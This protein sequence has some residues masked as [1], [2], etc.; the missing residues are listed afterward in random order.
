MRS[1]FTLI[2]GMILGTLSFAQPANDDCN[3]P[4][5]LGNLPACD[6]TIYSNV[7]ATAS[8]IGTR[9][10]P[11]CFNGGTTQ[12][13]VWFTFT[14]PSEIPDVT[15]FLQGTASGPNTKSISN[16]QIA[17]YR[18]D[19]TTNG[20][21]EIGCVSAPT[22]SNQVKL[23]VE[24][25]SGGVTYFVRINDYSATAASNAGDFSLCIDVLQ[26]AI[27]MGDATGSTACFGT[28]YDSGGPDGNYRNFEDL[29][30]T[31]CPSQP[32]SCIEIDLVDYGIEEPLLDIFGD[33]LSF[34]AGSNTSAPLI[35]RVYGQSPGTSFKIQARSECITIRFESD[36]LITDTGFELT[37]RC[38]PDACENR[39]FDNPTEI[40]NL[41]FIQSGFSTCLSAS[42]LSDTPCFNEEF[43]NGPEYVF[44]YNAPGGTCIS[45]EVLGANAGTGVLILDGPPSDPGTTC[46]ARAPGGIINSAN[47]QEAGTYY[48][49]V[50]NGS[51]CTPFDLRIEETT[52]SISPALVDALCNPLNGCAREDGLPT[53]F[54]F[55]PGFQDMELERDVNNGCWLGFGLEPN[56]YWFT[57]QANADGP[58]GFILDSADPSIQSDLDFNVWG[59]FTQEEVCDNKDEVI[60]FIR[61]NQPIRSS[62]SPTPGATGLANRHPVFNTPVTDEYDCDDTPGPDGDDFVRTIPA[63][64]GEV[65]V[66]LINDWSGFIEEDG[67]IVD[68]SPSSPPVISRLTTT[69]EV[70]DTAICLGES[71][72]LSID[73][74]IDAITWLN[75]TNTLSC[76]NCPNPVATPTKNTT[77]QALVDAVCYNDTISINVDVYNVNA[78]PDVTVCRNEQFDII[79]GETFNDATYEWTVPAGIS[80][81]CTDC[82]TP[83]VTATTPGTYQVTVVLNAPICTP[84][85]TVIITVRPEEAAQYEIAADTT[86]CLGEDINLGGNPFAGTTYDWSSVPDGFTS[87][88]ANPQVT[89]QQKTTY[90][91]MAG[92]AA[93]PI[94]KLD[95]VVVSVSIPPILQ[96]ATDTAVCQEQPIRL[97]FNEIED[98]VNYRWTG[99]ATIDNPSNPNTL[100]FP[101]SPGS[102]ILT[103]TRGA[104]EITDTVQVD[105][106]P[107]DIEILTDSQSIDTIR[108]CRG[109]EINFS[110]L[111]VP[112]GAQVIWSPNN[113]SLSDTTGLNVI[114][115]PETKTTYYATVRVDDCIRVDSVVV[116]VDSLPGDLSIMPGDTT[117]CQ[118]SLV[119]LK[120]PLYEPKDFMEID[121]QWVGQGQQTPD[122]LYNMVI[123]PDTTTQYYRITTN[124]V[125]VD[126]TYADVTVN[127]I[128]ILEI[129]PS[130]TTVCPGE[131]VQFRV[132]RMPDGVTKPMW[133]PATGLSC[134]ECFEPTASVISTTAFTLKAEYEGC[135]GEASATV[136]IFPQPV[137]QLNTQPVICQG[138]SIQLNFASTPGITYTWTSPDIPGFSSTDPRLV[139][140]PTQT[141]RYQ[142]V[143]Q[144]GGCD[145]V[146]GD[147]TITVVQPADVTVS[148]DQAI[149]RGE[150]VTLTAD[151][152]APAGVNETFLW[153]WN[154]Q[155][156]GG[157][158][159]TVT[160]LTQDTEFELVYVYGDNCGVVTKTVFVE[161]NEA[162]VIN[163]I[164][165]EPDTTTLFFGQVVTVS[166]ETTPANPP[167]ATYAWTANGQS[168]SGNVP[169]ITHQPTVTPTVYEVRITAPGGCVTTGNVSVTLEEPEVKIPNAF[170]PNGDGRNDFFNFIVAVPVD[171]I[172]FRV[173][174]RWG[175][176]VY[177]NGDPGRGW[178]G[179][180]NG[181]PAPS[182]VYVYQIILR[183]ASG[184]KTFSGD[185]TLIR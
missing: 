181:N 175:Q 144:A 112:Q 26:P 2:L 123:Q 58:F 21:S 84:R 106:T 92:N 63:R 95:S 183:F 132:N 165:V 105:I 142:V 126:T 23:D 110:A 50:A 30:F 70:S 27:N 101:T 179:T 158:S 184:D 82:P 17:L 83:I 163:R 14:I 178:D 151:G 12:R 45:V 24:G 33:F 78:G 1:L 3:A 7:G 68:W 146:Q 10:A 59:P 167:G 113:G 166:V 96:V 111:V 69:V 46:V 64:N 161:V 124:G 159:I 130:D 36:F 51:G 16:P 38:L 55:E 66:V 185:V 171:I 116:L 169:Q 22:G 57:I 98:N 89:P 143:A 25:L 80:F 15:I 125:C 157:A 148:Q 60:D 94:S 4:V 86:I 9:N 79:A 34:Y 29:T 154:G 53:V 145:P 8:N 170:T 138:E 131:P 73:S 168:I 102:Y 121:F 62:W 104:C 174:N 28:L 43:L 41:P 156:R 65:Y 172:Q 61:N 129:I 155:T 39:S 5:T 114:A 20:L 76:T 182:D 37:W 97:G 18:G 109:A 11:T 153:R 173:F 177:D 54:N 103:A 141:T 44:T 91:L 176:L 90:F 48:I 152:T 42:T 180:Q 160:N 164:T 85:D 134:T 75:D 120:S 135:P 67:V 32:N 117:I 87:N 99:P 6:N 35:S 115:K 150:S 147:I 71:V 49:V 100:A 74:P 19:C 140:T 13:D 47:V 149:C 72:Q 108:I 133:E 118:G 162:V 119:I 122:S 81:S 107:I 31:I 137:L 139:V 136:N 52:C 93:C 127:P 40:T 88:E 128:P 56:F 77:Y